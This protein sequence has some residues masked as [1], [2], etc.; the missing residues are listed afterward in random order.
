M[1]ITEGTCRCPRT[2]AVAAACGSCAKTGGVV[3]VV[4]PQP[5]FSPRKGDRVED[6]F[7]RSQDGAMTIGIV[8]KTV[9]G[10][11][12]VPRMSSGVVVTSV[13]GYDASHATGTPG[14]S[15]RELLSRSAPRE[16]LV[17]WLRFLGRNH[18][19]PTGTPGELGRESPSRSAP[20][21]RPVTPV[22]VARNLRRRSRPCSAAS[23]AAP[24][25]AG[26][27]GCAGSPGSG[28][29]NRPSVP[30]IA[31]RYSQAKPTSDNRNNEKNGS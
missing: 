12:R 30:P 19:L 9:P 11:S 22:R 29:S 10:L 6:G 5:R 15:G 16:R 24:R 2:S 26:S 4:E 31:R 1:T 21:E 17:A 3:A 7:P 14:E 20:R 23:S 25:S 27:R 8:A 18:G 28:A 13:G